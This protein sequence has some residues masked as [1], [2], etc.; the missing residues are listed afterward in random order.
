M[1]AIAKMD[2]ESRFDTETQDDLRRQYLEKIY[3]CAVVPNGPD[4]VPPRY[5]VQG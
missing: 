5:Y 3:G 1:G 4:G 2:D